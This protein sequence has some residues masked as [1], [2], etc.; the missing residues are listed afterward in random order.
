MRAILYSHDGLGL[1]HVRRNLA[2]ADAVTRLDP[3]A[4][5]LLVCSTDQVDSLVIPSRVDVLKIPGVRKTAD[6]TYAAHRLPMTEAETWSMRSGLIAS[7]T[8]S[9]APDVLLSDKHPHGA[10]G[11]LREALG[12]LHAAGGRAVLGLR[13]ILDDPATVRAEWQRGRVLAAIASDYDRVLVYGS[14]DVLHPGRAYGM[15]EPVLDMLRFC[16]YVASTPPVDERTELRSDDDGRPTVVATAGG[17]ADGYAMLSDFVRASRSAP[18]HPVVIS[19]ADASPAQQEGLRRDTEAID[20]TYHR[21]VR[22]LPLHF[23]DIA[24]LVS[25]G[26]YNTTVEALSSAVPTVVVPRV[27]PRQEQ[28]IRARAFGALGLVRVVEPDRLGGPA[29]HDQICAALTDSR[30]RIRHAVARHLD[31]DGARRAA[32]HLLA[33]A[34]RPDAASTPLAEPIPLSSRIRS[35]MDPVDVAV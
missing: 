2:I 18:W 8:R 25:M 32:A 29:L 35:A 1:G 24:A 16:G 6:A 12:V 5:V 19:G 10:H 30:S 17:G 27:E 31:L 15:P 28:L 26:G 3:A 34:D 7:A 23:A 22:N 4:S 13:D 11:E 21:F 14:P 33:L 20:G 9:F